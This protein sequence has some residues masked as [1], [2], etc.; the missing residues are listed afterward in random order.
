MLGSALPRAKGEFI[1]TIYLNEDENQK[2]AQSRGELFTH[3]P[4]HPRINQA[5]SKLNRE[6]GAPL[7]QWQENYDVLVNGI[8]RPRPV[9]SQHPM[10]QAPRHRDEHRRSREIP[11]QGPNVS[12]FTKPLFLSQLRRDQTALPQPTNPKNVKK[13]S[14]RERQSSGDPSWDVGAR[15]PE[16]EVG[17]QMDF[18]QIKGIERGGGGG[19]WCVKEI[20]PAEG[21]G[22]GSSSQI[23]E[24]RQR[25]IIQCW[26]TYQA[27]RFEPVVEQVIE[28]KYGTEEIYIFIRI[29]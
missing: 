29:K 22:G 9:I 16:P 17:R 23:T 1:Q 25:K 26:E 21:A 11:N 3:V 19:R 20:R 27:P 2:P 4:S 28:E 8:S 18:E 24:C 7:N 15:N 10:E 13:E 12:Q 14:P 5:V 6:E